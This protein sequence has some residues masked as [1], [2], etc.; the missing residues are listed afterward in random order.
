MRELSQNLVVLRKRFDVKVR[1]L[2]IL[3]NTAERYKSWIRRYL[4][5]CMLS[6]MSLSIESAESF[7]NTYESLNTKKQGY[8][9]LKFLFVKV[10]R[11]NNFFDFDVLVPKRPIRT[12]RWR[13]WWK[14]YIVNKYI[15]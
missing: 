11:L 14:R 3:P 5:F 6:K 2:R 13:K 10:G 12:E 9:A 1:E 7:L 15:S 8:Y 4:R